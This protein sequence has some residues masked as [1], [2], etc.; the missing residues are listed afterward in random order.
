MLNL[1]KY[2]NN[3]QNTD[4]LIYSLKNQLCNNF[5]NYLYKRGK[6]PKIKCSNCLFIFHQIGISRLN[7][8]FN[9]YGYKI[10]NLCI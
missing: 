7:V 10:K 8:T 5:N 6:K 2:V 4:L 9:I 3:R 1:L